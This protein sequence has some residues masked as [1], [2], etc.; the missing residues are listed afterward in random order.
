[1]NYFPNSKPYS[2]QT[3]YNQIDDG[4]WEMHSE[5]GIYPEYDQVRKEKHGP[6]SD[7]FIG[8]DIPQ[9]RNVHNTNLNPIY[10][11]NHENIQSLQRKN[12]RSRFPHDVGLEIHHIAN[13]HS[14]NG[15][16]RRP[17]SIA[18]SR[19]KNMIDQNACNRRS[20]RLSLNSNQIHSGFSRYPY[21]SITPTV[22]CLKPL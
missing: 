8:Y 12:N 10:I 9:F 4:I 7:P 21:K 6:R 20:K 17:Q 13:H 3:S 1:M 19:I 11:E 22:D 18:G 14:D 16:L 2:S 15:V 5:S